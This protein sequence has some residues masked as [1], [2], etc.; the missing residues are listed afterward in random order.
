MDSS[1][2]K[3]KVIISDCHLSAG[4]FF[5]GQLNP[6]EDFYFD[7]EMVEFFD[8][9]SNG[10]YGNHPGPSAG[11]TGEPV[12]VELIINGDYFDYLNVPYQG[13]F[14]E[15]ITEEIALYKTEAII[16]GH[17]QVMMAL[18][19][20]AAL[21]G[22]KITYLIG[23][24]DADLF[25]E[26]VRERITRE[27]DP[28]G[29]YP[30]EKVKLIA[31]QDRLLYEGGV[32]VRHGN[33]FEATNILNFEQ[34]LL[35]NYLEKP[36][37][38]I[39]WGSFYVL[40]IIN[41]LKWEREFIDKVRPIKVFV[42]FGMILDPWFTIRFVALSSFYFIK[43]RFTRSPKRRASWKVTM[44]ILRQETK[45]FLDLEEEARMVLDEREDLKTVIFGH[46]HRPMNKIYPD[47]KQYINTGTWTKMINLDWRGLGQQFRRTF[48][49]VQIEGDTAR[50]ELRQWAGEHSPHKVYNG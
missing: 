22:K 28:Q 45:M 41:R 36:V 40:K 20:F 11:T 47:G 16:A 14:E 7:D 24:H 39:P 29:Q 8:H 19:R 15:A 17:P 12:D 49:L 32:E 48:A 27:W 5:E 2:S 30:S 3:Y 4:K 6:H 35:T 10:R 46:T 31:D 43:T 34:P 33:Q 18:R 13:E 37:L 44:D 9:F 1:R 25:F 23:N 50:C 42:L 38:N 21:P 26:K